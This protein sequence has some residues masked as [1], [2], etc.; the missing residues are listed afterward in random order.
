[1][2]DKI[3]DCTASGC[4][5]TVGANVLMTLYWTGHVFAAEEDNDCTCLA[6]YRGFHADTT[7][8]SRQA[9]GQRSIFIVNAVPKPKSRISFVLKVVAD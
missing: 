5:W 7:A 6:K 3:F 9:S 8:G 4:P 2:F 1:M